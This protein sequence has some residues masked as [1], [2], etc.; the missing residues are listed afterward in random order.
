MD[1]VYI[2]AMGKFLPGPAVTNDEMEDYLGRIGDKP[3]RARARILKQNGI[4]SRHYALDK[5]QRSTHRNS[6]MAALAVRDALSRSEILLSDVQ[7]LATATTAGDV[8]A[9]GFASMVQGE[10]A[11]GRC[12]LASLSGICASGM[13]A[14]KTAY[15]HVRCGEKDSAVACASEFPSRLLKA[16]HYETNAAVLAG[17]SLPYSS[18]F[19]RWMLSDG[20]V[21][22]PSD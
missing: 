20:A 21:S 15:L 9:P 5:S 13:M 16:S 18:E 19:L 11:G 2:T 14:L 12:E 17:K 4:V 22:F 8:I 6:E 7:L 1:D 3:S 10:L